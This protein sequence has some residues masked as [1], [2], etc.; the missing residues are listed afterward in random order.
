M[1]ESSEQEVPPVVVKPVGRIKK[2]EEI[3]EKRTDRRKQVVATRNIKRKKA[4]GVC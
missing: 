3:K 4:S 2:K 1:S